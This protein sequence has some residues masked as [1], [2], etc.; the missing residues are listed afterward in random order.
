MAPAEVGSIVV[1]ED[2]HSMDVAVN[3]ENLAQAIGKGGQ[4]VRLASEL[5]GWNINVMTLQDA[6]DKQLQEA[7][8]TVNMFMQE[9]DIGEDI[10]IVLVEEG[11]TSVEEV[12]YVPLDE[13]SAIDDFDEDLSQELRVRAKDALLTMALVSEEKLTS[14]L[15]ADDLLSMEG[16]DRILA[17]KLAA[18]NIITMEDLAEQAV[19]DIS[20]IDDLSDQRAA[21]LIMTARAPWFE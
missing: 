21:E 14:S 9:L 6:E 15:P 11:F 4:N 7:T 16:M 2:S 12:A 19:D 5:T 17:H 18:K 8:V 3:E 13:M 10:A 20:G 1:D